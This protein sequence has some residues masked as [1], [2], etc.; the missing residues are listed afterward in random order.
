MD[1]KN[2]LTCRRFC[3]YDLSELGSF[4]SEEFFKLFFINIS[5]GSN[6]TISDRIY[7]LT[8]LAIIWYSYE[9]AKLREVALGRPVISIIK[10]VGNTIEIRNDGSNIAYNIKVHFLYRGFTKHKI[11][12]AILGKGLIYRIGVEDVKIKI[13]KNRE[14][15][16]LSLIDSSPPNP[17]LKVLIDYSDSIRSKRPFRNKWKLDDTVIMSS[18]GE[19]RFRMIW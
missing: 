12:I 3:F 1:N 5:G 9:T 19:G 6:I 11:G 17:N 10:N 8:L 4:S 14:V 2:C 13:D 18:A 16:L 7:F 15:D